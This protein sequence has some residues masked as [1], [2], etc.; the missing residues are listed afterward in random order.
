MAT[1][2]PT[3]LSLTASPLGGVNLL[4]LKAMLPADESLLGGWQFA[5]S[6]PAGDPAYLSLAVGGGFSPGGLD[7]WSYNGTTWTPHA[8]DD[9]TYDGTFASFT[10]T[11]LGGYGY[12][13]AATPILPGDANNDGRVDINDLTIVLTN[14]GR[15]GGMMWSQGD[16]TCDGRVDVND[17]TI[18]MANFGQSLAGSPA[19][20]SA[21]PEPSVLV[22]LAI[23]L[24]AIISGLRRGRSGGG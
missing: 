14:F 5:G 6:Y 7:V 24:P 4:L 9:L 12:A 22:L 21:V 19:A 8:A 18:V 16:F 3:P 13:V 11:A 2:D 15:T 17:L 23:G 20:L 10:E 1:E